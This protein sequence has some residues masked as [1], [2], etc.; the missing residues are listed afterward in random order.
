MGSSEKPGSFS[1]SL[2]KILHCILL[3]K[4]QVKENKVLME[5]GIIVKFSYS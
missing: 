2:N 4:I 1:P 3:E 5:K